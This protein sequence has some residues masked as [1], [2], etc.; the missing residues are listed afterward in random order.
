M[1]LF[2]HSC[3][4]FNC[5]CSLPRLDVLPAP[6]NGNMEIH[7]LLYII[8]VPSPLSL[9]FAFLIKFEAFCLT[10]VMSLLRMPV[11]R[12]VRGVV[13]LAAVCHPASVVLIS[14][15]TKWQWL[16]KGD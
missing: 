2:N 5:F 4:H 14:L 6:S 3:A 8:R 1:V 10:K 11:S 7:S 13:V 9:H 12:A 16:N 15:P